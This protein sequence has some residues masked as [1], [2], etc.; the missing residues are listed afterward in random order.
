MRRWAMLITRKD[1]DSSPAPVAETWRRIE[2]WLDEHLPAVKATLRRGI[3]KKDL[4]KF[5]RAIKRTLPE[6]VRESWRIHD[7]QG[8][9]ADE[10]WDFRS[11]IPEVRGL[12]FGQELIPL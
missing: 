6:D 9:L 4:N 10:F 3:S 2:A 8:A 1:N 12:I 11:T 7:G 5:E